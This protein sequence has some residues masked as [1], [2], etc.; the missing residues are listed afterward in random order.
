MF[1]RQRNKRVSSAISTRSQTSTFLQPCS[2]HKTVSCE[3]NRHFSSLR[4]FAHRVLLCRPT[5]AVAGRY[6]IICSLSSVPTP[7]GLSVSTA[8]RQPFRCLACS[9]GNLSRPTWALTSKTCC[10]AIRYMLLKCVCLARSSSIDSE[11]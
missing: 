7:D 5:G 8:S 6:N 4:R 1:G 9:P 2:L 10:A 3:S 11:Y